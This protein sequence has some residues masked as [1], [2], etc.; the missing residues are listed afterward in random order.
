ML[1]SKCDHVPRPESAEKPPLSIGA[2]PFA[3]KVAAEFEKLETGCRNDLYNF[4]GR[5]LISY[6]KFLKDPDGYK[7]LL[8]TKFQGFA[9]SP[10]CKRRR[11]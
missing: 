4:F 10:R 3:Q 1:T 7:A 5:A 6:R 11:G 9:R 8:R 2:M